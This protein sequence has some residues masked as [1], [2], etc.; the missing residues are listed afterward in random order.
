MAPEAPLAGL[1]TK[2][3]HHASYGAGN[4]VSAPNSPSDSRRVRDPP[5]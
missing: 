3:L 2:F 5:T 4:R 1:Y